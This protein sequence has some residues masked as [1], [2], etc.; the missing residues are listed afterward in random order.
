MKRTAVSVSEHKCVRTL[1]RAAVLEHNGLQTLL[2]AALQVQACSVHV[3]SK[4]A[5]RKY[6]Y[7]YGFAISISTLRVF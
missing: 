3:L 5:E 2:A 4:V 7:L 1:Q 6:L